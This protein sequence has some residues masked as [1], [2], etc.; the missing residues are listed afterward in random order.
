MQGTIQPVVRVA[1][2]DIIGPLLRLKEGVEEV[3]GSRLR[4]VSL[5]GTNRRRL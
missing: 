2:D 4:L 5:E 3:H 1:S